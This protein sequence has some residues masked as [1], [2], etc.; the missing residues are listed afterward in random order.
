MNTASR[1]PNTR[2]I[3]AFAYSALVVIVAVGSLAAFFPNFA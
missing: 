1:T 2:I 3:G